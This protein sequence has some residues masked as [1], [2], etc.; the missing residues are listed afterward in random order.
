MA[1]QSAAYG[2][3]FP[4]TIQMKP[5]EVGCLDSA[6]SSLQQMIHAPDRSGVV[7]KDFVS[8]ACGSQGLLEWARNFCSIGE[9][10]KDQLCY[11]EGHRA[12]PGECWAQQLQ[13]QLEE[14]FQ[15]CGQ[16]LVEEGAVEQGTEIANGSPSAVKALFMLLQRSMRLHESCTKA[17]HPEKMLWKVKIEV[18]QD[19]ACTKYHDDL[20]DVRFAM[21]LTGHGTVLADNTQVDWDY[22]QSCEGLIPEM[23]ENEA[24]APEEA[25][26]V[27]QTW[28]QRISKNEVT[29]EP[30]DLAVMKGGK[31][32]ERPCLHRAPYSAG[33]DLEP[34]R[35]L[36]TLDRIPQSELSQFVDLDFGDDDVEEEQATDQKADAPS[37]LLPA[38]VLSGFLGAG[39]T[40]LLTHVL[41]N[42]DGL[43]VA[44]IVND[45]AEVNIDALLV[46]SSAEIVTG[47]DKMIEMQNGCICCTLR[48]DLIENV[49]R[50]A[51]EK[52]FDYLLIESTGIS[53]PMPVATTF[54][55]EHD[56]KN[57][58]G[59]VARLDTLVTVVDAA[60]FMKDYDEEQ[61][62]SDKELGTDEKDQRTVA[63]LLV[64]QIECANLIV[65]NKIDLVEAAAVA[66]LEHLIKKLNPKAKIIRSAFS[67]VDPKLLLNT[68][69]FDMAEAEQMPGWY[70][71]LQGNHVPETLEYNISSFVFRERKPFHP[72]RLDKLLNNGLDDVLRS[73]G[74]LWV[75]GIHESALVWSQA[76]GTARIE[77][78]APWLHGSVDIKDWPLDTPVEYRGAQY[79]DRRQELV[80][81]GKNLGEAQLRQHLQHALVTD[82]E[83]EMGLDE[84]TKWPNPFADETEDDDG[85]ASKTEQERKKQKIGHG[86]GS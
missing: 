80:F 54:V 29:A 44:V 23:A 64:D 12:E 16:A 67:K 58:L 77:S 18:N 17:D 24:L 63:Q 3:T 33:E 15:E 34:V 47:K 5:V 48:D 43:R 55:S 28:N 26:G 40:S 65:I 42:Q 25:R 73:K 79:G 60:N 49:S 4:A 71:E 56:G 30:G 22:Y 13:R 10:V 45:M 37:T 50:L 70:Q 68:G 46:K 8:D 75:A 61:R 14:D 85:A 38:T 66:R 86:K 32:T 41:Q 84:W 57:L 51:A 69:S 82:A 74:V 21:T 81:I 53:E 83:F 11:Y 20:I 1:S 31:L 78:G 19:G 52:R 2:S 6:E 62:L 27:I 76:G 9:P 7:L 35:L 72:E 36:I 59:S 39:K